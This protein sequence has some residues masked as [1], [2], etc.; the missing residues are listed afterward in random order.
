VN[1]LGI[2]NFA[3]NFCVEGGAN[4]EYWRNLPRPA[5]ISE[6]FFFS[7][8]T[9]CIYNAGMKETLIRQKWPA[10]TD[11]F[12]DFD[13]DM[14]VSN[15]SQVW[16]VALKVFNHPGKCD[17]VINSA[18]NIIKDRPINEKM[19]SMTE[20]E[21]LKYFQS[22]PYI[23][24]VTRYHIARNVGFDVVK[25]D[26]HLVRIAEFLK[27]QTPDALVQEIAN[28]TGERKGFIDYII[29]QWLSWQGQSAYETLKLYCT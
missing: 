5:D 25:P 20:D 26:R 18:I 19:A 22:Y 24:R 11:A 13:A 9:W 3:L 23:G 16:A 15:F 21:A 10:L 2:W 8:L 12:H 6:K 7:E 4:L 27:Y 14:I 29:W 1:L 17:A 28:L